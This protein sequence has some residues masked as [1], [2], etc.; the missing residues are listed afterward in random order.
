MA[1]QRIFI[2]FLFFMLCCDLV[3][4]PVLYA[5]NRVAL[6][7]SRVKFWT[8]LDQV[9]DNCDL[10]GRLDRDVFDYAMIGYFNLRQKNYLNNPKI[11]SIADYSQPS[12][13]KRFFV[14][15]LNREQ[16]LFN[17]LVAHGK[18]TGKTYAR[19]FSNRPDS[20]QS[21]LGFVVTEDTYYGKHGLSLRLKGTEER[22]NSNCLQRYIVVHGADYAT[23][24]FVQ[25]YGRLGRSWGCPALP[26]DVSCQVIDRIQD[27]TCFFSFYNDE[28]YLASSEFLDFEAAL[29]AFAGAES[30][31]LK[32][33]TSF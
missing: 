17:S 1:I 7:D 10:T 27:G 26:R 15:D 19:W 14:L 11:L 4:S 8:Y 31:M 13:A 21:S 12:T 30:D 3:L 22:Y 5:K 20:K 33:R 25:E 29:D 6:S 2:P 23:E 32:H 16:L 28:E 9:Y 24:D 18:N